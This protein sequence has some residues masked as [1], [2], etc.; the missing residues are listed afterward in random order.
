MSDKFPRTH[1]ATTRRPDLLMPRAPD[2]PAVAP[3]LHPQELIGGPTVAQDLVM[4]LG[5]YRDLLA[6]ALWRRSSPRLEKEDR[7]VNFQT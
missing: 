1:V 5:L 6:M 3:G 4:L 7:T 2:T